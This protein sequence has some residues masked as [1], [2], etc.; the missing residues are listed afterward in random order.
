M[1]DTLHVLVTHLI[2]IT[3]LWHR[4]YELMGLRSSYKVI[5]LVRG[6][7]W[8]WSQA[9]TCSKW[10]KLAQIMKGR[11]KSPSLR[12]HVYPYRFASHHLW[13]LSQHLQGKIL[14]L[15]SIPYSLCQD[16][17]EMLDYISHSVR[18]PQYFSFF[19]F[20]PHL[21]HVEVPRPGIKPVPQL[22]PEPQLQQCQILNML[23]HRE[24]PSISY[25]YNSF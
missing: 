14:S 13:A 8:C 25:S 20:L 4:S 7:A 18:S 17:K 12:T 23:Y 5:Q 11:G 2:C 3:T 24:L 21:Q 19:F 1:A 15:H 9:V 16:A 22:Q 6:G 10:M